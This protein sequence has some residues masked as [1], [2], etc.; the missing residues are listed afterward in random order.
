MAPRREILSNN[1][2]IYAS[3]GARPG[4]HHRY[5]E[6]RSLA[7]TSA[8]KAA[9]EAAAAGLSAAL[10]LEYIMLS[11]VKKVSDRMPWILWNL[12]VEARSRERAAGP[13]SLREV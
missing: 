1:E 2:V 7:R 4:A 3:W 9:F 8:L 12:P 10:C 5:A 6:H 11:D 13:G